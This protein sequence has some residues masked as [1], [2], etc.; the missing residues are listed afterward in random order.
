[1]DPTPNWSGSSPPSAAGSRSMPRRP[2]ATDWSGPQ[3]S[4]SSLK[5]ERL[6]APVGQTIERV[7]Q[8][9]RLANVRLQLRENSMMGLGRSAGEAQH[10]TG[11]W[12]DSV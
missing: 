9:C 4:V 5:T 10:G 3:P 1:M 11:S 2:P 12:L 6:S 8:L 7:L